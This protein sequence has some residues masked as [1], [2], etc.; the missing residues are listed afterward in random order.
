MPKN[1]PR[2]SRRGQ[3]L[4]PSPIQE[5]EEAVDAEKSASETKRAW[6]KA[7]KKKINKVFA[8]ISNSFDSGLIYLI[9]NPPHDPAY[10]LSKIIMHFEPDDINTTDELF[11]KLHNIKLSS[12]SGN[13]DKMKNTL[14]NVREK[15]KSQG[16]SVTETHLINIL[17]KG[18]QAPTIQSS[19]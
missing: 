18:Y 17:L 14:W 8:L 19:K 3:N 16:E 6:G 2:R 7:Y 15:L 13:F 11:D 4:E 9:K 1:F 10:A 5:E 12:F